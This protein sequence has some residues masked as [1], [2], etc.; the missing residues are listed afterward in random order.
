MDEREQAI[1]TVNSAIS[2]LQRIDELYAIANNISQQSIAT[3]T[4]ADSRKKQRSGN[5]FL[6]FW[7]A[8]I[9]GEI[10][11]NVVEELFHN[12]VLSFIVLAATICLVMKYSQK[13][14]K[15]DN[16]ND[17]NQTSKVLIQNG[18]VYEQIS[19]EIEQIANENREVIN[20][21]PR[22]YRYYDAVAFF[23]NA[24]ANGRADSM[25]EAVNL[26]ETHLHQ[27]RLENANQQ[28]L[29]INEQ[30]SKMMAEIEKNTRDAKRATELNTAFNV[31][32]FLS[33]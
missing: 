16:D 17:D 23:E 22:D 1:K 8:F 26:Y 24:L 14:I 19:A 7:I 4:K 13:Q 33:R 30:Q 2:P 5:K 10:V 9:L 21:I 25:K 29:F 20:A 12:S 18:Q 32:Y 3:K 15:K 28:M 11:A 31:L 6:V 27:M